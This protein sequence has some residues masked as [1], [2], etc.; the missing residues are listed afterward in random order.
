MTAITS[1]RA[2]KNLAATIMK[3]C[4]DRE[5]VIIEHG[6]HH[7][8]VMIPLEE[9]ESICETEHQ[10]RSPA[11]VKRLDESLAQLNAGLGKERPINW[12]A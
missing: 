9:Y 5:A 11:N 8:V 12:D 1:A 6:E 2:S 7:R 10:M 3:V 4:D